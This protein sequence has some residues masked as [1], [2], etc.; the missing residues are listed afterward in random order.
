MTRVRARAPRATTE[1]VLAR[2]AAER[3]RRRVAAPLVAALRDVPDPV[4]RFHVA[5]RLLPIMHDVG[6][7]YPEC[8]LASAAGNVTRHL[9]L[10]GLR[11]PEVRGA[12]SNVRELLAF[13]SRS[14]VVERAAALVVVIALLRAGVELHRVDD[15]PIDA[16]AERLHAWRERDLAPD[17]DAIVRAALV[18]C[19]WS[20]QD[21]EIACRAMVERV[22]RAEARRRRGRP[23]A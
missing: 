11:S 16:L 1:E 2:V 7:R 9:T 13:R 4:E 15:G 21:A 20:K 23:T 19:G 5:A 8:G 6:R 22:S 10:D 18:A 14:R 3:Q 12:C 17:D